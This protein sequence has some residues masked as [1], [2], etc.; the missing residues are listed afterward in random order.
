[1][2]GRAAVGHD[3]LMWLDAHLDIFM[4]T[5]LVSVDSTGGSK[6]FVCKLPGRRF[7][8]ISAILE[9][10]TPEPARRSQLR[11]S[12][13]IQLPLLTPLVDEKADQGLEPAEIMSMARRDPDGS[14]R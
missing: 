5:Y 2:S 4:G 1:M 12:V 6:P 7:Q 11:S 3:P 13:R 14:K 9:T 8:L 10:Q